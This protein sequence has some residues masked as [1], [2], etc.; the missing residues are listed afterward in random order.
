M[1]EM[2]CHVLCRQSTGYPEYIKYWKIDPS[3][4]KDPNK[5][6]MAAEMNRHFSKEEVQ[7]HEKVFSMFG[8]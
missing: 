5:S 3:E 4:I 7:L 8:Q 6:K 2:F 1:G